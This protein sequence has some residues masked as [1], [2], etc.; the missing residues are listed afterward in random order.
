[1]PLSDALKWN[2]RY[3]EEKFKS[4]ELPRPFLVENAGYL[5]E[6]GLALDMAMGLG[7]NAGFL[8][9]RGLRVIGLD[10]SEVAVLSAKSRNPELISAVVDLTCIQLPSNRFDVIL[11]FYYLQR[12]LWPVY[13]RALRPRGILIF[14]SLTQQMLEH[15]P[16]IDPEFLL[17]PA[18][19]KQ[20]FRDL[21][22]LV[23]REDWVIDDKGH[24][25]AVASLV[26]RKT[27]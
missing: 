18:E 5:P 10:I 16:N 23:Y 24:D 26:A 14:E 9:G 27:A 20:G 22:I 25:K 7:G 12:D 3:K 8:S 13:Q 21:E 2:Q 11:N 17:A 4:F 15:S 1:M 6:D 19:L